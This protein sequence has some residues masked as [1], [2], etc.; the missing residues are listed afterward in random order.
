MQKIDDRQSKSARKSAAAV[1]GAADSAQETLAAVI[2]RIP[3]THC[4]K[5]PSIASKKEYKKKA[6][7]K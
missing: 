7:G 6:M 2:V 1:T 5:N 4:Y 3:R